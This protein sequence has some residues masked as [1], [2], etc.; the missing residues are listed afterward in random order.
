MSRQITSR[1]TLDTLKAEAKR[2]LKALRANN[3]EARARLD[4]AL[5]EAPPAPTLRDVQH[6]LA[7]EHGLQGWTALRHRLSPESPMRRYEAVAEALVVAYRTADEGAM[8]VVWEYF[9]HRRTWEAMRRYVRLDLGKP[10]QP[11]SPDDDQISLA[12]AQSLVARAQDFESWSALEQYMAAVPPGRTLAAKAIALVSAGQSR[13][14]EVVGRSRDWDEVID[15]VRSRRLEGVGAFGQMTDAILERL[16]RLDHLEML[17]LNTSKGLT[18]EGLRHLAR[19][20]RLRWLNLGGCP[21]ITDRGLRVL[22]HL[23]ALETINLA[24]TNVT[25]D[26]ARNL[27]ACDRLRE[28]D[29]SATGTGD[30]TIRALAGKTDLASFRSGNEV[31]DAGLAFLHDLPVFKTWRGGDPK[32]SL[33]DFDAG[34]NFLMLRG[35]FTDAGFAQL[36]GLDGLFALNVDNDRLS[37]TGRA[38]APL[39]DLPHLEWLAFDAKDDSMPYIAALPRLRFLMCQDTTA[40]DEGFVALSRSQSIEHIWGRRCYNLQRRGFT[41]LADMPALAHLSVS[42][43]NVDDTGLAALPRFPALRELMPMDV[44]D[45]GYRHIGQCRELTSLVLMYCRDTGDTATSHITRLPNL[46]KYFT[47]YTRITDRTPEMLAGIS[48]LEEITFDSCAGLTNAGVAALA[49]LPRLRRVSVSGMKNVTA[50]V[51]AAFGPGVDVRR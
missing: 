31:T 28:V 24:W 19:L 33:L 22:R 7:R 3:D 46:K 29:L 6:A 4:R 8:R 30:D 25:D 1:T 26:G 11:V 35:P 9:G 5:P 43:R 32:M 21:G 48:S 15:L 47:S 41:A 12:E 44:P 20:P 23:P 14:G 50:D 40:G 16:C 42:C 37:I 18:D 13:A 38:L 36:A 34:P 45:E 39:V 27:A 51:A 2:W 10:E 17:G 49:R